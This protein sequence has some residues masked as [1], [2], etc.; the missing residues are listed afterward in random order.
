MKSPIDLTLIG[1]DED[2]RPPS[3]KRART[4][5]ASDHAMQR[6]SIGSVISIGSDS[7]VKESSRR[8]RR[9]RKSSFD[10]IEDE[11]AVR[12]ED[13]PP[14]SLHQQ[15]HPALSNNTSLMLKSLL[16]TSHGGRAGSIQIEARRGGAK[17]C[18]KVG[19]SNQESP[20]EADQVMREGAPRVEKRRSSRLQAPSSLIV[21]VGEDVVQVGEDVGVFHFSPGRD[22][23]REEIP[24][25]LGSEERGSAV[26]RKVKRPSRS[27]LS[28]PCSLSEFDK[29][30]EEEE[31]DSLFPSQA[32]A[33]K[34]RRGK[35]TEEEKQVEA[36]EKARVKEEKK[37]AKE[38]E[39]EE[40]KA[41][42]E[43]A[44][45]EK[46]ALALTQ[47]ALR[48]TDG[49]ARI[50]VKFSTQA[51]TSKWYGAALSSI[52]AVLSLPASARDVCETP[53][54]PPL[55]LGSELAIVTWTRMM[56]R[57]AA[58]VLIARGGSGGSAKAVGASGG[59]AGAS[60]G[61]GVVRGAK[62][63]YG[64]EVELTVPLVLVVMSPEDL[65]SRVE[66]DRLEGLIN[67]M[68][69]EYPE[70]S[71]LVACY[72][73]EPHLAKKQ[74]KTPGFNARLVEELIMDLVVSPSSTALHLRLD[75]RDEGHL[76]SF[77]AEETRVIAR[78]LQKGH[79]GFLSSFSRKGE[80]IDHTLPRGEHDEATRT[81]CKALT[82]N[83]LL[84]MDKAA[85]VAVRFKS[86]GSLLDAYD[87]PAKSEK[88]KRELLV[89]SNMSGTKNLG[90]T[91]STAVYDLLTRKKADE[92]VQRAS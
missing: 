37:K 27:G 17:G 33:I 49:E 8:R 86:L 6:R 78:D 40:K 48:G 84:P 34:A 45:I 77:V 51:A 56:P 87:D 22:E 89:G 67:K 31:E 32:P 36:E 66:R 64:M 59:A 24:L 44:K 16:G 57:D 52:N 65:V 25:G 72:G 82:Q 75:L 18:E 73:L 80:G 12:K 53:L 79:D 85:A 69:A 38:R 19:H 5:N 61:A 1:S 63:T 68:A 55:A 41:A 91:S 28:S 15:P 92:L 14:P 43:A 42:T 3:S 50:R 54:Y 39:R 62:D 47:K 26:K 9:T 2:S 70:C 90:I 30:A 83:C 71:L 11:P 60:G 7:E 74:A 88:Q 58:Q 29:D 21:Q 20:R 46:K 76:A 35:K 13:P 10:V 23:P 4:G 81:F